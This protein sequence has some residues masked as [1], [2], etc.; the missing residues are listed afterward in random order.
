MKTKSWRKKKIKVAKSWRWEWKKSSVIWFWFF[1]IGRNEGK[2][3]KIKS[4]SKMCNSQIPKKLPP[5]KIICIKN[6]CI[7]QREYVCQVNNTWQQLSFA[8]QG[9]T[10]YQYVYSWQN[11]VISFGSLNQFVQQNR[12]HFESCRQHAGDFT[13]PSKHITLKGK[14]CKLYLLRNSHRS[15]WWGKNW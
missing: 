12:C 11:C 1:Y 9:N 3:E 15:G 5:T 7:F 8:L 2:K 14:Y 6:K 13:V 4:A 10:L